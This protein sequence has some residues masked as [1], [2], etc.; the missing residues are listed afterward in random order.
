[1]KGKQ[2]SHQL[3]AKQTTFG[4]AGKNPY[5]QSLYINSY[6]GRT[7]HR[8]VFL[9]VCLHVHGVLLVDVHHFNPDILENVNGLVQIQKAIPFFEF[10]GLIL[11]FLYNE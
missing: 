4:W 8:K 1:M 7:S 3:W 2:I 10:R 6:F 9:S 11:D 5:Y